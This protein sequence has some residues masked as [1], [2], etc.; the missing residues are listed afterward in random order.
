MR[1]LPRAYLVHFSA[2]HQ[3]SRKLVRLPDVTLATIDRDGVGYIKLEG[4]SE[5][6]AVRRQCPN[7][8]LSTCPPALTRPGTHNAS[9]SLGKSAMVPRGSSA[10]C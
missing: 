8:P 2:W 10:A 9:R 1:R 6:T 4:F 7:P 3:V 5:G